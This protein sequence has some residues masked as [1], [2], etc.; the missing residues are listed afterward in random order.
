MTDVSRCRRR[1]FEREMQLQLGV[2]SPRMR[3]ISST[4][5]LLC[6]SIGVL[7]ER[8]AAQE[9]SEVP[10]APAITLTEVLR[11]AQRDPPAVLVAYA[12][13]T[14]AQADRSY[15]KG[16][17]YPALTGQGS[18][19]Y[20]YDN[21]LVLPGVPRIDSQAIEARASLNLDW[22]ALNVARGARIDSAEAAERASRFGIDTARAQASVIAAA[23]YLQAGAA[24]ELVDDAK[25]SVERRTHQ[26]EAAEQLVKA[27]T[28][29]P[30]DVQRAKI[31]VL[32]AE[33]A[34]SLRRTDELA[35]FAALA[36][37]IGR[38]ADQWVRPASNTAE[39]AVVATSPAR[40][41]ELAEKNR[42]ELLGAAANIDAL[43][44]AHDADVGERWPTLGIA[45]NGTISYLDVRR[46]VGLDGDQYTAAGAVYLRWNGFDPAVWMRGSVSDAAVSVADRERQALLHSI[47]A[48]S[49]AAFFGL[50]RAKTEH[51]RAVAVLEAAQVTREAQ[52]GRYAAGVGSLL[53]LL[54]AE[55]LE[56]QARQRRIEA[57]RDESIASAQLQS[58]CGM[59]GR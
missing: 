4:F 59:L 20:N 57:E 10:A 41:K 47:A 55:D 33:Y 30:V 15:A 3:S 36:S 13:L 53:E 51:Q 12:Q 19:G 54:D 8:S 56:Q 2:C 45:A 43:R 6:V 42:P 37:A 40:A 38:P 9:L 23:L 27:G 7:C 28:R 22:S 34:L 32:S 11:A 58:A 39:F 52:N 18:V 14:R 1:C 29:S 48:E 49:V 25:L 46:G 31:E 16:G 44:Y 21:H 35:A 26:L 50:E 24:I 17:W 5:V